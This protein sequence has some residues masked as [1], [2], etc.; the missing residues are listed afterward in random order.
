MVLSHGKCQFLTLE[1]MI[2]ESL[3]DFPCGNIRMKNIWKEKLLDIMIENKVATRHLNHFCEVL[4][5]RLNPFPKLR[6]FP[7]NF[8]QRTMVNS[9]MRSWFLLFNFLVFKQKF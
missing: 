9:V 1:F 4:S 3:I 6:K 2:V 7:P 8:H 5:Q